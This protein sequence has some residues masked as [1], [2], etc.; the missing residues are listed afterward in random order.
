MI[1]DAQLSVGGNQIPPPS[2][3]GIT[4]QPF[5]IAGAFYSRRIMNCGCHIYKLSLTEI[6][7]LHYASSRTVSIFSGEFCIT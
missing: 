3:A 7:N 2:A 1:G 6:H 5:G 4:F